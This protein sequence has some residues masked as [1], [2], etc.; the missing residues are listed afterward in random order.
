MTGA[1]SQNVA[2]K[3]KLLIFG[4]FIIDFILLKIISKLSN[5]SFN[6]AFEHLPICYNITHAYW[7][8]VNET[9]YSISALN[10]CQGTSYKALIV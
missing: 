4:A 6:K 9:Y 2:Y 3:N 10:K 8:R 5:I 7:S 1:L